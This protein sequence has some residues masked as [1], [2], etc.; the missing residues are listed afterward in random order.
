MEVAEKTSKEAAARQFRMCM[1]DG[2][3]LNRILENTNVDE[4]EL[5]TSNWL[6][7]RATR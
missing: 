6:S 1:I 2:N 3:E 4:F 7:M 5:P